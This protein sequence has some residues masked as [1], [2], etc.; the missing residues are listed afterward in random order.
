MK[1]EYMKLMGYYTTANKAA[2]TPDNPR[3]AYINLSLVN[4]WIKTTVVINGQ[5]IS[6]PRWLLLDHLSIEQILDPKRQSVRRSKDRLT[7]QPE[8]TKMLAERGYRFGKCMNAHIPKPHLS[9]KEITELGYADTVRQE[10]R[11]KSITHGD[12]VKKIMVSF[13]E[14]RPDHTCNKDAVVACMD[15]YG[16][17][18]FE[19]QAAWLLYRRKENQWIAPN[20]PENLQL[21]G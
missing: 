7:I 9:V 6:I 8:L 20:D 21:P 18:W 17:N 2:F 12:V 11:E 14:I 10:L 3:T 1:K 16:W 5:F 4:N 19:F 15:E 13:F